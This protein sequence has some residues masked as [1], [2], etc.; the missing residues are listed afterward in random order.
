M[1]DLTDV[2]YYESEDCGRAACAR[3]LL[4]DGDAAGMFRVANPR[5]PD[6]VMRDIALQDAGEHRFRTAGEHLGTTNFERRD[7]N[8]AYKGVRGAHSHGD[9]TDNIVWSRAGDW[10]HH[11]GRGPREAVTGGSRAR[12]G[13]VVYF[14][15]VVQCL[16]LRR[17]GCSLCIP[18]RVYVCEECETCGHSESGAT[19]KS[20]PKIS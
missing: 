7:A 14:P 13:A 15:G 6:G 16:P 9:R 4:N 1:M 11:A 2:W 8:S 5:G 19:E 18:E 17:R 10:D 3:Q 12:F 20:L